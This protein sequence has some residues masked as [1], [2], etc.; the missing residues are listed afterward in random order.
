MKI[1]RAKYGPTQ[2]WK[3]VRDKTSGAARRAA[4][5]KVPATVKV[6]CVGDG[7]VVRDMVV[8]AVVISLVS[9]DMSALMVSRRNCRQPGSK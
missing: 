7:V 4:E 1:V 5:R 2:P 3:R 6:S 8:G 9:F